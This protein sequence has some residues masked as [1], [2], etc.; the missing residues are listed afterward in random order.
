MEVIRTIRPGL[1]GTRRFQKHWGD[2]LIAVRYRRD[3]RKLYTTIEIVV[4]ERDQP[5]SGVSLNGVHAFKRR[6]LVAIPIAFEERALRAV[7]KQNKAMWSVRKKVWVMPYNTAVALGVQNRII[8]GLAEKC[9][10][11]ELFFD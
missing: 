3:A 4:D 7:A 1:P 6:Q 10:D 8:E 5:P 11:V 2:N 9:A